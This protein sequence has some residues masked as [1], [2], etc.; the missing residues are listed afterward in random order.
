ME[1]VLC[2]AAPSDPQA[3]TVAD[4]LRS[5][6]L[7]LGCPVG[8]LETPGVKHH[9]RRGES[10]G[11]VRTFAR[12]DVGIVSV[13]S[14]TEGHVP[15][16]SDEITELLE[17]TRSDVEPGAML[18]FREARLIV[19][20]EPAAVAILDEGTLRPRSGAA[21]MLV[22]NPKQ[23]VMDALRGTVSEREWREGGGDMEG[24]QRVGALAGGI[25]VALATAEQPTGRLARVRVIVAPTHR[26][27]GFGRVV[28]HETAR[29]ALGEGMLPYCRLPI[30]DVASRAL[31][32]AVGFVAFAH[33]LTMRPVVA[34]R[35]SGMLQSN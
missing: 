4:G 23:S 24:V 13:P 31:A 14:G 26:R 20:D 12:G 21:T 18:T 8:F 10:D 17:L 9:P 34:D 27:L 29:R 2:D 5:L 28:L 1:K 22:Y 19:S 16:Q 11:L 7:A 6:A 30:G 33:A 32:D 3:R 15:F 25:L 35:E